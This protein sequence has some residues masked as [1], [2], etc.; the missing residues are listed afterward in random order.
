MENNTCSIILRPRL[1]VSAGPGFCRDGSKSSV[2]F[3]HILGF[4]NSLTEC[5]RD[6][7]SAVS[8]I[9]NFQFQ[10]PRDAPDTLCGGV[11]G[12]PAH[13]GPPKPSEAN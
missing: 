7:F 9:S 5:F 10:T 3:L 6:D 13:R 1:P 4:G 2:R 8:E 11:E 12:A